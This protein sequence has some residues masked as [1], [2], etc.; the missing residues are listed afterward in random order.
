M[1]ARQAAHEL[2]QLCGR[3][4]VGFGSHHF[5]GVERRRAP[6]ALLALCLARQPVFWDG[7]RLLAFLALL[8]V[9]RLVGVSG[10]RRHPPQPHFL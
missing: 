9:V 8:R 7:R 5:H 2:G 1:R 4:A 3:H 6:H 10:Y